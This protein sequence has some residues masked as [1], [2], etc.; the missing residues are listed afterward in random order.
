MIKFQKLSDVAELTVGYV[1]TMG[2]EYSS[3]GVLFLRSL[4]IKPFRF[5]LSDIKYIPEEFHRKLNKSALHTNDVVIV[6]TGV[7][8]TC[9]VIPPELDG[10]NCADLVIVR[11]N[12]E[13]IDPYF[14]CAFINSWGRAQV[15]NVKVG[16]VQK[17]FNV[18]SAEEM[19]IPVIDIKA[20]R[21]ISDLLHKINDKIDNNNAI[22]ADLEA[23][24]K[25]LYD[26]ILDPKGG[27]ASLPSFNITPIIDGVELPEGMK[28][29]SEITKNSLPVDWEDLAEIGDDMMDQFNQFFK[30]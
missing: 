7:P 16:A 21:A 19:L 28:S 22:C 23:M 13:V 2:R 14:L 24:A 1:G 30:K 8:G 29:A 5:D 11:P 25:L 15:S 26:F 6:R 9:S 27:Q 17:H 10:C 18:T 12:Q 20:Q 3:Q 4:N